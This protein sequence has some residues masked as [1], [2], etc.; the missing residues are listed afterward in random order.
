MYA[1][2]HEDVTPSDPSL[3]LMIKVSTMS[4]ISA[5]LQSRCG[6]TV[7][8]IKRNVKAAP[9]FSSIE[10]FW[11]VWEGKVLDEE[12]LLS[13][14]G[15]SSDLELVLISKNPKVSQENQFIPKG[16]L[17]ENEILQRRPTI[18]P[19]DPETFIVTLP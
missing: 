5:T 4:S 18:V 15:V 3:R 6:V 9:E 2:R 12:K 13:A 7:S 19:N 1:S 11:L 8:E 17:T 10:D 16:E 14:Y